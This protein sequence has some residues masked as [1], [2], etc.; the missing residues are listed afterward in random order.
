[1]DSK[2]LKA[3]H[4]GGTQRGLGKSIFPGYFVLEDRF[5][6]GEAPLPEERS[7]AGRSNRARGINYSKEWS[8]DS[9]RLKAKHE[10]GTATHTQCLPANFGGGTEI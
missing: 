3:K 7:D 6:E 4:E 2:R 1:V 10:G 8:V 9:K 5:Q